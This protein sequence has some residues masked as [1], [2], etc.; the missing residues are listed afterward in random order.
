MHLR[1]VNMRFSYRNSFSKPSPK[2]YETLL[3]DVMRGD[4]SLFMRADQVEAAWQIMLPVL[5]VWRNAS[6]PDF[7]NYPVGSWGPVSAE[8][9]I[10]RDG[11]SW[12]T[13]TLPQAC[14]CLGACLWCVLVFNLAVVVGVVVVWLVCLVC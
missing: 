3:W 1:P 2:A 14:A 8:L 7:P 11:R 13:P 4:A 9:L 5:E 12:L 6:P 10:A